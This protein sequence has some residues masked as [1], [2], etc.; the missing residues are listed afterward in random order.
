MSDLR[1]AWKVESLAGWLKVK[2]G[3]K[4][5]SRKGLDWKQQM[6]R[7]CNRWIDVP[8]DVYVS[9]PGTCKYISYV[10]IEAYRHD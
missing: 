7:G 1:N 6:A 5:K 10:T 4:G 9:I 3:R 2:S 8:K